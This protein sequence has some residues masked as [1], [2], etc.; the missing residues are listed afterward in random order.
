MFS[1]SARVVTCVL[2]KSTVVS[3][4]SFPYPATT[5][6]TT[7]NHGTGVISYLFNSKKDM[8]LYSLRKAVATALAIHTDWSEVDEGQVPTHDDITL[9]V[10]D[11]AAALDII[12]QD[13]DVG[14]DAEVVAVLQQL[15]T[16]P[17]WLWSSFGC[18]LI[19]KGST[20]VVRFLN[21]TIPKAAFPHAPL[22]SLDLDEVACLALKDVIDDE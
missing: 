16:M 19:V 20:S 21:S 9:P 7:P 4:R 6:T 12:L 14:K 5:M 11:M 10:L 17:F 3:I 15:A 1:G 22:V 13:C 8:Y 2:F 18:L